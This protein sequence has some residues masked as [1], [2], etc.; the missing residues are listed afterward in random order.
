MPSGTQTVC[1]IMDAIDHNK[2]RYPR[3]KQVMSSKEFSSFIR[4]A[5]DLTAVLCHGH[6]V[7]LCLSEPF[8]PKNSSWCSEL[9]CHT[10][11]QLPIDLRSAEIFLQADNTS[12]EC[13]NNSLTRLCG[14]L[15]G[16]HRVKRMEMRFLMTGHSHDDVDQYFSAVSNH[17]EQ[18]SEVHTPQEFISVLDRWMSN[19]SIRPNEPKRFVYKVDQCRDWIPDLAFIKFPVFMAD[20][21]QALLFFLQFRVILQPSF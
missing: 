10:L 15:T 16:L 14:L 8:V 3:S 17:L 7:L 4:P 1:L 5:M 21:N 18:N 13:K 20:P 12:R 11:H 9:L 6:L 19:R 2:F